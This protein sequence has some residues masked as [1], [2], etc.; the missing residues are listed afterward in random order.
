[1]LVDLIISISSEHLLVVWSA[2]QLPALCSPSAQI[3]FD[4]MT[5]PL[6]VVHSVFENVLDITVDVPIARTTISCTA[7]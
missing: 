5:K 6:Q 3:L 2:L 7:A 1:M 4:P